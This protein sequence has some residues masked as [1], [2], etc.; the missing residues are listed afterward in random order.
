MIVKMNDGTTT[1]LGPGDVGE[2]PP[3][4]DAWVVGNVPCVGIDFKGGANYARM[5]EK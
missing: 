2:I 5:A 3:G 4:H 1:E